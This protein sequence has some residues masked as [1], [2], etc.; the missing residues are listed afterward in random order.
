MPDPWVHALNLDKAVREGGVVQA[1]VSQEDYDGVKP[2]ICQVWQGKRWKNLFA[3]V[4]SHG[5]ELLPIRVFLGYLRGYFLY[6]EVPEDDQKFWSHF[7]EELGI[8]R[9]Q[10][11]LSLPTLDEYDRL[12]QAL[13]WHR[14]TQPHLRVFKNGKRD[15]IGTLDTIFHFKALRLK[16]LKDAFVTFYQTGH[17]SEEAKPYERMFGKLREAL[18]VL[19]GEERINLRDQEAVLSFLE[20]VGI[21]L[22]EPNPI[23]LLFNR[24]ERAL[25]DIYLRL[26]GGNP[27]SH[28]EFS[29]TRFRHKQ[30]KVRLLE[31]SVPLEGVWPTLSREPLLEGWRVYGKVVLEDGRFKRFSWVPRY[32]IEGTPIPEDIEVAF[33]EGESVR[34]RLEHKAFAVRFSHSIWRVGEDLEVRYIGF[35]PAQYPLRFLL[36]ESG[37]VGQTLQELTERVN[38][39]GVSPTDALVVEVRIDGR[40]GEWR[41]IG[42]LPLKVDVLLEGWVAPEG[43]FIRIRPPGFRVGV[44]VFAGGRLVQEKEVETEPQGTLVA[45]PG[46]VPLRIEACYGDKVFYLNLPPRGWA[47]EWWRLGLGWGAFLRGCT[48]AE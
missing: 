24:S 5:E 47:G 41:R 29:S 4:R 39:V 19:L 21:V 22:G 46:L 15:F 25:E 34:F 45:L 31:S 26:G 42:L 12:W 14:E 48:S 28:S 38:E 33:E 2:L 3:T 23:R 1:R 18:E 30:V 27:K 10:R 35:D 37:E 32:T 20:E 40:R 16:A 8:E 6:R 17:L 7:L 9:S 36:S 11:K 43:A 44:R 13:G